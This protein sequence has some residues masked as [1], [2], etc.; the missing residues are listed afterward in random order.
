MNTANIIQG[1]R[2]VYNIAK[3]MNEIDVSDTNARY[4]GSVCPS[5][6]VKHRALT[7]IIYL[8]TKRSR[9][10]IGNHI[11]V[12]LIK[13]IG[14]FEVWKVQPMV[15]WSHLS[16]PRRPSALASLAYSAMNS[17][18]SSKV[19]RV[20]EYVCYT[21]MVLALYNLYN[22]SSIFRKP[23]TDVQLLCVIVTN[24]KIKL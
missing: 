1:I 13:T 7:S 21:K 10:N 2:G 15:W 18:G 12:W 16:C 3:N 17:S 11:Q 24:I 19:E 6:I 9:A 23:R 4:W 22:Q 5:L 14:D 8:P 20:E